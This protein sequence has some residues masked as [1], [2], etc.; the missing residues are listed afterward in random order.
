M[1]Q[2]LRGGPLN[3][4]DDY[5]KQLQGDFLPLNQPK[6]DI[7]AYDTKMAIDNWI[8]P[9]TSK[10]SKKK[11]NIC[12]NLVYIM[13]MY[14]SFGGKVRRL[15]KIYSCDQ[16]MYIFQYNPAAIH[17]FYL[18]LLAPTVL[19]ITWKLIL[20]KNCLKRMIS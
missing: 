18:L 15:T 4:V 9:L 3:N 17:V 13:Y 10:K 19:E 2:F 1:A 6:R 8:K 14:T 11:K 16:M 20:L 5:W 7:E 12:P